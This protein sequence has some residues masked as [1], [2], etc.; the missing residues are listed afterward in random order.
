[1]PGPVI[2]A[3]AGD[4]PRKGMA[5]ELAASA[6]AFRPVVKAARREGGRT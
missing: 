6:L 5:T 2:A 4:L 3:Y 1:M